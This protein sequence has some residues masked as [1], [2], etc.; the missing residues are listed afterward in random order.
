MPIFNPP[1][2]DHSVII[3]LLDRAIS[4]NHP[5]NALEI[6]VF[7]GQ[8]TQF[9]ASKTKAIQGKTYVVDWWKANTNGVPQSY[10]TGDWETSCNT[11]A[12]ASDGY[13]TFCNNM[14][15][16]GLFDNIEIYNM[17]SDEAATKFADEFFD[18]IFIDAAHYYTQVKKDIHNFFPKLK[19][20]GIFSGHDCEARLEQLDI[21]TVNQ[22]CELDG[23]PGHNI[24]YGVVKAVG[25]TFK[26]YQVS[27]AIWYLT[28]VSNNI[29]DH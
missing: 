3:S 19:V 18:F 2:V 14:K 28:K 7:Q 6:G 4:S 25:E 9:I 29:A 23:V 12:F 26:T 20:G 21:N 24:H 15:E 16:L 1:S 27:N 8:T 22:Y 11:D 13:N 5:F 17:T 10:P